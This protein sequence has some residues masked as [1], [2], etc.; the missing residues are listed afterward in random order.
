MTILWTFFLL[1]TLLWPL[2]QRYRINQR[3]LR[4]TRCPLT[5]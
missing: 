3:R 1:Y 5:L 4:Q 2:I